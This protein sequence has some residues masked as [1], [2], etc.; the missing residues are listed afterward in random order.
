MKKI[1]RILFV[2]LLMLATGSLA[3]AQS[4]P[5]MI[6]YQGKVQVAGVPH[7]G[8]GFFKFA[9]IDDPTTP[10][11]NY[12]TNDGSTP[13]A[14]AEPSSASTL[15]VSLGLF[16]VKLGNTNLTNMTALSA[17]I[18][19]TPTLYLRVWFSSDGTTF[20]QLAPDRQLVSVPYAYQAQ[21]ANTADN[22]SSG[23][24]TSD[25]IFDGTVTGSDI[26]SGTI[27]TTNITDGTIT[28]TNIADGT[29]TG[30]D[31]ANFYIIIRIRTVDSY[32]ACTTRNIIV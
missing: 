4:I 15:S 5:L 29:V 13:A 24:V 7:N 32:I 22:V 17:S 25:M 6:N 16:S 1:G 9:L 18:F 11:T 23:G 12:W 30:I 14:G 26:A 27:T 31:I 8:Q 28:T 21:T 19:T 3:V 10:T 2:A 20:E